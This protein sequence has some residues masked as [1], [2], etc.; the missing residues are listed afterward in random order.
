MIACRRAPRHPFQVAFFIVFPLFVVRT[1][2]A[3]VTATFYICFQLLL[4]HKSFSIS[5]SIVLMYY[6]Y[7]YL[8]HQKLWHLKYSLFQKLGDLI[9]QKRDPFFLS[10][11]GL[12]I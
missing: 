11:G 2:L 5:R 4:I 6:T 12:L 1:N 3:I 8:H 10:I 7:P 9:L